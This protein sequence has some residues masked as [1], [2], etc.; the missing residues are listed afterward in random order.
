MMVAARS[1]ND[2][3]YVHVLKN[4]KVKTITPQDQLDIHIKSKKFMESFCKKN[5]NKK[6]VVIKKEA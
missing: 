5:P 6:I 1:L 4:K 3:R 2:F